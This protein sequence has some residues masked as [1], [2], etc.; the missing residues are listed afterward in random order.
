M[1]IW[2]QEEG[3]ILTEGECLERERERERDLKE[4]TSGKKGWKKGEKKDTLNEACTGL[5]F[6]FISQ[7]AEKE[8]LLF[9][10]PKFSLQPNIIIIENWNFM[11]A[12]IAEI[13]IPENEYDGLGGIL[14]KK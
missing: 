11:L 13:K 8:N 10:I 5:Y 14:G 7:I 4:K 12:T 6:D 9:F 3:E 1:G 2:A